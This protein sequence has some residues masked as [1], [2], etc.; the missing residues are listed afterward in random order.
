MAFK[1][2]DVTKAPSTRGACTVIHG[3]GG[4]GKTTFCANWARDKMGLF[5]QCEDGLSPLMI[6]D[7]DRTPTIDSLDSF[8]DVLRALMSEKHDYKVVFIDTID[9]L[10]PHLESYVVKTYYG[11]DE[12]KANAYKAKYEEMNQEF[13]K[14]LMACQ[15][16][17]GKGVDVVFI[18]HSVIAKAKDP[19]SEEYDRWRLNLPGGAKTSLADM[20]YNYADNVFFANFDVTVTD[21]KGRGGSRVA[22]TSWTPAYDA[23]CRLSGRGMPDKIPFDYDSYKAVVDGLVSKN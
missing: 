23:K 6:D 11:G 21:K 5:I 14:I 20:L 9:A 22:Y 15:I 13:N 18:V 3:V 10:M 19:S 8:K 2:S 4:V 16:L 7:V 1:L 17:Q 12:G